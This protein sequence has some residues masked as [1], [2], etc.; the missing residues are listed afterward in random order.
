MVG[1]AAP[2]VQGQLAEEFAGMKPEEVKNIISTIAKLS[3]ST[4]LSVRAIKSILLTCY[5]AAAAAPL[6]QAATAATGARHDMKEKLKADTSKTRQQKEDLLGYAHIHAWNGILKAALNTL[7]GAAHENLKQYMM[8]HAALGWK[9]T[10]KM[11]KYCRIAKTNSKNDKRLELNM[12]ENSEAQNIWFTTV[13]K[14]WLVQERSHRLP[15]M[16]APGDM[17]RKI[18]EFLDKIGAS[19]QKESA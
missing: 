1:G 15:N 17:E 2:T 9:A 6:V 13:E 7:K 18:Q 16:A 11:V 12:V 8:K 4:A 3:L 14:A 10:A 5:M 19:G